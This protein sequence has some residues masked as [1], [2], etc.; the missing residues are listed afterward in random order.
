MRAAHIVGQDLQAPHRV[1]VRALGEQH[2]AALREATPLL[3]P[4]VPGAPPLHEPRVFVVTTGA[5]EAAE[6]TDGEEQR[7]GEARGDD[8]L[9]H[10]KLSLSVL[11][12]LLSAAT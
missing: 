8:D 4:I 7:R 5:T 12:T 6:A 11:L 1:G 2:V 3:T 10:G 9:T